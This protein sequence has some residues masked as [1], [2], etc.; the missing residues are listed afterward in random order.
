[1][2]VGG[3]RCHCHEPRRARERVLIGACYNHVM[4]FCHVDLEMPLNIVLVSV[5]DN[6]CR[7]AM[8]EA[9]TCDEDL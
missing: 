5:P 9:E 4:L 7:K 1:M 8:F 2:G 6:S 3:R